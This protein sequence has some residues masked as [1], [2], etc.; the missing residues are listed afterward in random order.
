[1]AIF[2]AYKIAPLI[3]VIGLTTKIENYYKRSFLKAKGKWHDVS[4]WFPFSD[5][6]K[7]STINTTKSSQKYSASRRTIYEFAV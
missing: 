6:E 7:R 5:I 4:E 1:L 3:N 2:P